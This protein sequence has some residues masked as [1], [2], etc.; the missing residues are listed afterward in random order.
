MKPTPCTTNSCRWIAAGIVIASSLYITSCKK[1]QP[2]PESSQ[3]PICRVIKYL[4]KDQA[5]GKYSG[6]EYA[7]TTD[8]KLST[9]A[10]LGSDSTAQNGAMSL[11]FI[12]DQ[13]QLQKLHVKVKN[14]DNG[15]LVEAD[16]NFSYANGQISRVFNSV[17]GEEVFARNYTY[18]AD[19]SVE[20]VVAVY[21]NKPIY[22]SVFSGYV[23][24]RPTE[25]SWFSYD[26]KAQS[27]GLYYKEKYTYNADNNV[28]KIERMKKNETI[29]VLAEEF[30]YDLKLPLDPMENLFSLFSDDV[31]KDLNAG[32][33]NTNSYAPNEHMVY[34]DICFPDPTLKKWKVTTTTVTKRSADADER[35]LE[36]TTKEETMEC[37]GAVEKSTTTTVKVT[38]KCN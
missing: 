27:Y 10:Y 37:G 19:G 7:Y 33:K 17:V 3:K 25:M 5:T 1:P 8:G 36:L 21:L 18:N 29:W 34:D 35:P 38:Y 4:G 11:Q 31:M 6:M 2:E 30:K 9:V 16:M 26:E 28:I 32:T 12:Y 22:K 15:K 23:N 20:T 24:G 14:K 13:N